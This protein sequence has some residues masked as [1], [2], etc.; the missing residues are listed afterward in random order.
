MKKF[1]VTAICLISCALLLLIFLS[2]QGIIHR[3]DENLPPQTLPQETLPPPE[4][5]LPPETAATTLSETAETTSPET[6]A[7]PET[8]TDVSEPPVTTVS[9]A[10]A[11]GT[12]A[13]ETEAAAAAETAESQTSASSETTPAT[14]PEPIPEPEQEIIASSDYTDSKGNRW[15][16]DL[17]SIEISDCLPEGISLSDAVDAYGTVGDVTNESGLATSRGDRIFDHLSD[18]G[19]Y[20]GHLG[21]SFVWATLRLDLT[22]ESGES[23]FINLGDTNLCGGKLIEVKYAGAT[24]KRYELQLP[25]GYMN[26][27]DH[28][29]DIPENMQYYMLYVKSGETK[30]LTLCYLIDE[31]TADGNLYL[32]QNIHNNGRTYSYFKV[33]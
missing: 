32:E 23:E 33:K 27:H 19:E 4:I 2:Q 21:K 6:A 7:V 10:F 25:L 15:R 17:Y 18:T 9:E 22:L 20:D 24:A 8:T 26:L 1:L 31:Q 30:E 28:M 13:L 29:E 14:E 5:T 12:T 3:S 16:Y 11:E